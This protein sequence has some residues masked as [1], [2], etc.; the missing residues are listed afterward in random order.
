ML[1]SRAIQTAVRLVLPGELAKHAVS[2]GTKAVTRFL[3][4]SS[5][6]I[7]RRCRA[8]LQ[9]CVEAS[10]AVASNLHPGHVL[11]EHA[12][13]Y[14]T[15]VCEYMIAELMELSGNAARSDRK[16]VIEPTHMLKAL[17]DDDELD[18]MTKR[19]TVAGGGRTPSVDARLLRMAQE[20]P[21]AQAEEPGAAAGGFGSVFAKMLR[22]VEGGALIDP[23]DGRHYRLVE[24]T[25]AADDDDDEPEGKLAPVP[26]LDVASGYTAETLQM[27][28]LLSLTKAQRLAFDADARDA[29]LQLDQRLAQVKAAQADTAM[30]LD[31][32]AFCRLVFEVGQ[33]FKTDLRYTVEAIDCLQTAAEAQMVAVYALANKH[34]LDAGRCGIVP[35]DLVA[36]RGY[37]DEIR[38]F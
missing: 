1:D 33:D 31:S 22:A 11:S 12:A 38:R 21:A 29:K 24:A 7:E 20:T 36:A 14:L 32:E 8:G 2:E 5:K 27:A 30:Q 19:V 13:C 28:A 15:A 34:A 18:E 35:A 10:A 3:S 4:Q 17:R 26:A 25:G 9:F 16:D 23:R 6:S 37:T